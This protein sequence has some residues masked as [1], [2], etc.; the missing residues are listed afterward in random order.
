M[1][2]SLLNLARIQSLEDHRKIPSWTINCQFLCQ[3]GH[4]LLH[5]FENVYPMNLIDVKYSIRSPHRNSRLFDIIIKTSNLQYIENRYFRNYK[6][7]PLKNIGAFLQIMPC[8]Y[9][10]IV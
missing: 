4:L 8:C 9:I 10:V 2:Y 7:F 6:S 1:M 3:L 5:N